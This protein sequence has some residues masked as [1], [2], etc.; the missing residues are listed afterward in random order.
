MLKVSYKIILFKI[1]SQQN[2]K[3]K[4]FFNSKRLKINNKKIK[5]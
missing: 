5:T 1:K 3:S 2:I 4:V